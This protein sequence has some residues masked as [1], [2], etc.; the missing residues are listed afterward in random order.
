MSRTEGLKYMLLVARI[1]YKTSILREKEVF[2]GSE[3]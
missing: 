1:N 3:T 2:I